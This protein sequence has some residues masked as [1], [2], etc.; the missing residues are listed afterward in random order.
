MLPGALEEV[1]GPIACELV[2]RE[3]PRPTY[4]AASMA[5][6]GPFGAARSFPLTPTGPPAPTP[7]ILVGPQK[8]VEV[9]G[10]LEYHARTQDYIR[11]RLRTVAKLLIEARKGTPLKIS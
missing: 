1:E 9:T 2:C 8:R 4:P 10:R 11:Q 5:Q 6:R 7:H 3:P